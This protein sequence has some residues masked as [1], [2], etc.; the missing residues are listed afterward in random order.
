M[1]NRSYN[2]FNEN[3][4]I[5][6]LQF[7]FRQQYST[8]HALISLTEDVMKNLD[9]GNIDCGIFADLQKAFDT[10]EHDI[11]LTKLENY[12]ING[13]GNEWFKS[14]RFDRKQFVSINGH[15]SNKASI[16]FVVPHGSV[17]GPLLFLIYVNVLDH[18]IK[19]CKFHHFV[20][21]TNFV[22]FSKSVNKL[23]N[24]INI[25]IK[26]LTNW[27]N[28]NKISLNARKP[29]LAIL[30]EGKTRVRLKIIT[31]QKKDLRIINNQP[32]NSHSCPLFKKS[33]IL[34]FEDKTLISSI[35]FIS[36]S[37][38]NLLPPIFKN[39]FIFCSKLH[40]YDT[41]SLSTNKLFKPSYRTSYNLL[42]Y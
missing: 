29:E 42:K 4:L 9:K 31:L 38:N 13:I 3:N 20:D 16:K 39:W 36:K 2:F 8:S 33:N 14:Y 41:V 6:P 19:F 37:I 5:Y 7:G 18:A 40:N 35:I 34:K 11:L 27:L 10:V 1:F 26:N 28:A 22:H 25:D 21:D 30:Y 23:N 12:G 15:V 17:L 24:Y 32:K